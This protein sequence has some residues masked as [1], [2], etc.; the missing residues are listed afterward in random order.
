MSGIV[1]AN[2]GKHGIR[3][4]GIPCIR[5][6]E[7]AI[8]QMPAATDHG[9][10]DAELPASFRATTNIDILALAAGNELLLLYLVQ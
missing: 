10:I 8:S 7:R 2:E 4:I 5:G 3:C 1:L 6:K 9:Q